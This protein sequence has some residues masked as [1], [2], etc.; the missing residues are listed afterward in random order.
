VGFSFVLFSRLHLV[1]DKG[2]LKFFPY[3]ILLF[4]IVLHVLINVAAGGTLGLVGWRVIGL[5]NPAFFAFQEAILSSLYIYLFLRFMRQ[6][7]SL[8]LETRSMFFFLIATQVFIVL[9]DTGLILLI[10]YHVEILKLLLTPLLYATKLL[11]EY[12]VLNR[13][14]RFGQRDHELR[15]FTASGAAQVSVVD[16]GSAGSVSSVGSVSV[17]PEPDLTQSREED[18]EG[19]APRTNYGL[20]E[21]RGSFDAFEKRYLGRF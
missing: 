8:D 2:K 1:I 16:G 15:R 17:D 10:A 4:D 14:V 3:I 18:I 6:S 21:E 19:S 11:L 5:L 13:L 7:S 20:D 9:V 12:L